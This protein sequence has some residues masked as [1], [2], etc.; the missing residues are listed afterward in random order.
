MLCRNSG[1]LLSIIYCRYVDWLTLKYNC[2]VLQCVEPTPETPPP[3]PP[4]PPQGGTCGNG[5]VGNGI[6]PIETECCRRVKLVQC[7]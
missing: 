1:E 6:C 5:K 4:L 7:V 2:I 3:V